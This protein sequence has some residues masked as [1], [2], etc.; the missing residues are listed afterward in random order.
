MKLTYYALCYH[1][2]GE[3]HPFIGDV[4][5]LKVTT[6]G[7]SVEELLAMLQDAVLEILPDRYDDDG[8]P[9]A[10][11]DIDG[12]RTKAD[13]D[14]GAISFVLPVTVFPKP[15]TRNIAVS[16]PED[17]LAK[18]DAFCEATGVSRSSLMVDGALALT[19]KRRKTVRQSASN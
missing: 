16:V 7:D 9:P 11:S 18:I 4:P 14:L 2:P 17:A 3:I 8:N 6:E 19:H 13:P 5:D 15:R 12:V 1:V 10:P